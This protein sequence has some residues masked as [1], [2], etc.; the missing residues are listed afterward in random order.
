MSIDPVEFTE[1]NPVSFNRYAYANNSPYAFYDPDGKFPVDYFVDGV[2]ISISAA[3]F[4][5][6][7]SIGNGLALAADVALGAIPFVPSGIGLLRGADKA[8]DAAKV[9]EEANSLQKQAADLVKLNDGK[10]RVTLRSQEQQIQIDL[11]GKAHNGI[12][13]PHTKVSPRNKQAP[14]SNRPRYNTSKSQSETRSSSQQDI[15]TARRYLER[16]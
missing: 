4:A 6:D 5:N 13:T 3:I 7:P 16:K 1:T 8:A 10:S 11:T 15:R 2:S 14:E 12:S 9:A